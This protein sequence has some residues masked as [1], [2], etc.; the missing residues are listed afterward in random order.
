MSEKLLM[1]KYLLI[2]FVSMS[3]SFTSCH[4][5]C[6]IYFDEHQDPFNANGLWIMNTILLGDKE[7]KHGT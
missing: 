4:D 2:C 5:V 1:R 7:R 3:E 6:T